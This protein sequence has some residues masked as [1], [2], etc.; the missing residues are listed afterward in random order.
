MTPDEWRQ[1]ASLF[2][3]ALEQPPDRREAWLSASGAAASMIAEVRSLLA[4]HDAPGV[5]LDAPAIANGTRLGPYKVIGRAGEG[6]MGVVFEAEDTRLHRRVALKMVSPRLVADTRARQ[7][8]QQEARAAG[9]LSHPGI[10]TIYALDEADGHLFIVSE[11]LDGET[12]R[13]ELARGPLS[14]DLARATGLAVARGLAAAHARGVVHRDLKPENIVRTRDGAVKILDFGLAQIDGRRSSLSS[15]TQP[16]DIGLAGT[17]AYMA[18]EQLLGTGTDAR[19]DQFAFGVLLYELFE[20]RTPFRGDTLPSR[21]AHILN[22]DPDVPASGYMPADV[23]GAVQRCLQKSPGDRFPTTDELAS[24]LD[25]HGTLAP[26]HPGTAP[27]SSAPLWWWQFHQVAAFAA[28]WAMV[29]PA[30]HVHQ[31]TSPVFGLH[32]FF[33][34]LAAVIGAANLR[35][36]LWFSSRVYPGDLPAQRA[37]LRGSIRAADMALTLLALGAGLTLASDHAEWA[38]LFVGFGLGAALS[39]LVIEPA[40]SRAAFRGQ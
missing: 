27:P 33:A 40:T 2:D 21:V 25:R 17:P 9:A 24:A 7:R 4:S 19:T 18:P 32:F 8:L 29:W 26:G 34:V 35:L 5:F 1:V 12:L 14:P 23:W 16:S 6:G 38:A 30:W 13:D 11:F 22:S 15:G 39:Y 3:G 37:R 10:A 36:H 20:G 31:W 28:Y